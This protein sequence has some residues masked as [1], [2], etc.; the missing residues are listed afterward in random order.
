MSLKWF[1]I[2]F[3][4]VAV[5]LCGGF[6]LWCLAAENASQYRALGIGS[7]VVGLGL[8]VYGIMFLKKMKQMPKGKRAAV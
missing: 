7:L 2:F 8:I 1:H 6:G 5:L 4:T 3:V